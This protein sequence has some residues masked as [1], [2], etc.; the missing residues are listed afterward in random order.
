MRLQGRLTFLAVLVAGTTGCGGGEPSSR[1]DPGVAEGVETVE[2][3][4]AGEVAAADLPDIREADTAVPDATTDL[5][6]DGPAADGSDAPDADAPDASDA[7][8]GPGD[9]PHEAVAPVCL[10]PQLPQSCIAQLRGVRG[11]QARRVR[12]RSWSRSGR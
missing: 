11:R 5:P 10:A 2:A 12:A 7:P 3:G 9:I 1:P 6:G 4:E 8:D